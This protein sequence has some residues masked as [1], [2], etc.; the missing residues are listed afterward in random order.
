MSSIQS[1]VVAFFWGVWNDGVNDDKELSRFGGCRRCWQWWKMTWPS[2]S[3]CDLLVPRDKHVWEL[4]HGSRD[5]V[6]GFT[7]LQKSKIELMFYRGSQL[8]NSNVTVT[9][10][11]SKPE[12]QCSLGQGISCPWRLLG[13]E[14]K[15]PSKWRAPSPK[16]SVHSNDLL[17]CSHEGPENDVVAINSHK[18][19]NCRNLL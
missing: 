8:F 5:S 13:L 14:C 12:H 1:V 9:T 7:Y 4:T 10:I 11:D 15:I 16:P 2:F 19:R 18:P 6:Q 3:R 17:R